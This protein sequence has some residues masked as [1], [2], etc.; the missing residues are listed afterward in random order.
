MSAPRVTFA[1]ASR[2]IGGAE[3]SM[4]RLMARAHPGPLD[5]RV[6]EPGREEPLAAR[7]GHRP[8]RPVPRGSRRSISSAGYRCLR[9]APA[10]RPLRV[11]PLPHRCPGPSGA[12]L[13]GVRCIVA[14]ERSAANRS[15]DRLARRLDRP[16]V[17]AYVANS[18]SRR[19]QP[20]RR[21]WAQ[22]G[23]PVHVVPNGIDG[24][25]R[26]PCARTPPRAPFAA[27]RRA[28][29]RANKGQGVLLEAVRLLRA[30]SPGTARRARRPR[31]HRRPLLARGRGARP[32]GHL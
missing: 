26:R 27:L 14:A 10:G 25:R 3:R 32:R 11:R 2:G 8:R 18:E 31:L 22:S 15:S 13:A 28:T 7:G 5:C 6:I 12:R 9:D 30:A 20:A 16:L 17:T 4:L 24:D 21:S 1:F 23:P 29:S 19:P